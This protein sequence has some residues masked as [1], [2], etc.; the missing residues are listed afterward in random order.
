MINLN[1]VDFEID[2]TD[3]ETIEKIE[4]GI[5]VVDEK[6]DDVKA[7]LNEKTSL[8]EGVKQVCKILKDFLDDILGKDSSKK[9]FG[10]KNS[11]NLCIKVYQDLINERNRQ[12]DNLQKVFEEYSPDRLER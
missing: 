12:Y 5:K 3:A 1:G 10:D 7:N 8:A 4:N 2:F 11:Y 9:I 6:I